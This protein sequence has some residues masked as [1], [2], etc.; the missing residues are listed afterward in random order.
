[1][2][3]DRLKSIVAIAGGLLG[4][5]YILNP[6][7]GIIEFIPDNIPYI[8][9]LDE[10]AAVVLILGCLRHFNVDLTKHFKGKKKS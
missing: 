6:T 3:K 8:G 7:A 2:N 5:L 1:M 4:L 10:A 9:N